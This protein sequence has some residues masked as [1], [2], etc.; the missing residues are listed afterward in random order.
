MVA[1][2]KRLEPLRAG[3][4]A[5]PTVH[6]IW[7]RPSGSDHWVI[8][9]LLE[10]RDEAHW[11]YRRDPRIRRPV[12]QVFAR[13]NAGLPYLR[14]EIQLLYKSKSPRPKDSTDFAA[15]WPFLDS[16]AK[17]WLASAVRS[18]SPACPWDLS[19]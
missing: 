2:D 12:T 3:S 17:T 8:E 9:I 4:T 15:A 19:S 16:E 14:P 18:A 7:C 6:S 13:N 1:R 5:D 11:T 10:D